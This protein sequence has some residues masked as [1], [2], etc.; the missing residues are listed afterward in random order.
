MTEA[1]VLRV[2]GMRKEFPGVLALDWAPDDEFVLHAGEIVGLV[3]E[4]GA[5]KSTLVQIIAGIYQR[6]AGEIWLD[7]RSYHAENAVHARAQGV[8][9]V[10]QEPALLPTLTV[11]D[12]IFLGKEAGYRN[13]LG[14]LALRRRDE[15]AAR[16]LDEFGLPIEP[17]AI[18]STLD[19]E[20]RKLVELVKATFERPEVLII[21]ETAAALSLD[22]QRLLFDHLRELKTE[23]VGTIYITHHL[24]EVFEVCDRVV[25]MKDGQLVANLR[26]EST[27]EDE[28]ATLMVGRELRTGY[29]RDDREE[30]R[31]DRPAL[32]V[33]DLAVEGVLEG[34]SF[35]LYEGE[36]L[37]IGGLVGAGADTIG[38]AIFGD[39]VPT[40]GVLRR[41]GDRI[42]ISSPADALHRRVG[43]VPKDRDREGLIL[44]HSVRHNIAM[45]ILPRLVRWL[46]VDGAEEQNVTQRY[47]D[48]LRIK[49]PSLDTLCLNLS[50][51]NRQKVVLAKWLAADSDVL[52]LNNPTRGVDVGAKAEIYHLMMELKREGLAILMI[53]EELPE[54][55]GMSDRILIVRKGKIS[56]EF[57]RSANPTEEEIIQYMI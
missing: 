50:G 43:Y 10:M 31:R 34:V 22:G 30:S 28:V 57:H 23:G 37:G 26:T 33:E 40:R 25:V 41:N 32:R 44:R 21:D 39:I 27:D 35:D 19:Y 56:G 3:G 15:M 16:V 46:L 6:T 11:S 4:N 54:L 17:D 53:S 38:R 42:D 18:V 9:I 2:T 24:D 49:A 8:A 12:N 20:H 55:L 29:Y 36:I 7:G 52:I 47:F 1:P 51:G 48:R 45:P 13:A 14:V 5:G